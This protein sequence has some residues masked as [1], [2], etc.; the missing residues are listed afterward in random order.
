MTK[1]QPETMLTARVPVSLVKS[2]DRAAG[3]QG[4]TRSGELIHRLRQS[5]KSDRQRTPA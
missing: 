2:L 1:K 3:R 4:R 5:L